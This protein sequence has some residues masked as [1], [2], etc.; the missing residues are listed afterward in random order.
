MDNSTKA[1]ILNA[2]VNV[3]AGAVTLISDVS[4][5]H[6]AEVWPAATT[7][8]RAADELLQMVINTPSPALTA[9]PAAPTAPR[10]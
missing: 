2:T 1:A 4:P 7:L 9:R 5:D 3:I 6:Q 10:R 8:L